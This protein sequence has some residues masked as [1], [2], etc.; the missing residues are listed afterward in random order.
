MASP[1][2]EPGLKKREK[3]LEM[4]M[5]TG[6][7]IPVLR[8]GGAGLEGSQRRKLSAPSHPRSPGNTG[9]ERGG[10]SSKGGKIQRKDCARDWLE[11]TE[12]GGVIRDGAQLGGKYRRSLI[13]LVFPF[14]SF[15]SNFHHG[16]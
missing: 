15:A 1:L 10:C 3:E 9:K 8:A 16:F 4:L 13:Y 11:R 2:V 14:I 7:F 12:R 5:G 6:A